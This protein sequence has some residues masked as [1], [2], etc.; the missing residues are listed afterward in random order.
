MWEKSLSGNANLSGVE[1]LGRQVYHQEGSDGL[2]QLG[3]SYPN[4]GASDYQ[5]DFRESFSVPL[6]LCFPFGSNRASLWKYVTSLLCW[7]LRILPWCERDKVW[8]NSSFK[9]TT[10]DVKYTGSSF[11][12]TAWTLSLCQLWQNQLLVWRW[13][14][15][16]VWVNMQLNS[17]PTLYVTQTLSLIYHGVFIK[18]VEPAA[19]TVS[20]HSEF[21]SC[22]WFVGIESARMC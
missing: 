20:R 15:T 21:W 16:I 10:I 8:P 5:K 11:S 19:Q 9:E 2:L 22:P 17:T 18:T 3:G 7:I 6:F 4:T 1:L 12:L 13:E 14:S